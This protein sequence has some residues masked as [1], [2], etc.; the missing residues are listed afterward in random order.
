MQKIWEYRQKKFSVLFETKIL[1][2]K[3][4]EQ[5]KNEHLFIFGDIFG[6]SVFSENFL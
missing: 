4:K 1:N 6:N 5:K 2:N 3:K